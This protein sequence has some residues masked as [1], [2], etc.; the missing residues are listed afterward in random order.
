MS[1]TELTMTE[2]YTS[3]GV[4]TVPEEGGTNLLQ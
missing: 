4:R 3:R 1:L 2:P